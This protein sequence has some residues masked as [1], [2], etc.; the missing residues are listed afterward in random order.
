VERVGRLPVI[1]T[2]SPLPYT[3]IIKRVPVDAVEKYFRGRDEN[4]EKRRGV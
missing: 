2:L 3:Q 4:E 1:I